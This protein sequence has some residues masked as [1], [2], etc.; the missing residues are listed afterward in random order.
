[1]LKSYNITI[2]VPIYN[3]GKY[4]ARCAESLFAQTLYDI[5]YIFVNDCT[6]DNSI[7]ILNEAIANHPNRKGDIKIISHKVNKG[8]AA[9]RN[10]GLSEATGEYIFHCDSDDWVAI[11][12]CE[13]MYNKAK[14]TDADIVW[15]DYFEDRLNGQFCIMQKFEEDSTKCIK[16]MLSTSMKWNLWNKIFKRSLFIEE[17]V[18]FINGCN[19]GEDL[20]T[21]KMFYYAKK[22]AYLPQA[23]YHYNTIN[24][25]SY[26]S[27]QIMQSKQNE[28]FANI[29]S[30]ETF[31]RETKD[32]A[33]VEPYIHY[34]KIWTKIRIISGNTDKILLRKF[35][36]MYP[37]SNNYMATTPHLSNK[38]K[39]LLYLANKKYINLII[40]YN[41]L[42]KLLRK[43]KIYK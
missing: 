40:V 9:S 19:L 35:C 1:M 41:S 38:A 13:K 32:Y 30:L 42:A 36:N 28:S 17:G 20:A 8:L 31:F 29:E 24:T 34:L 25:S 3:V 37:E 10:A 6:P 15:S 33:V 5:E 18:K 21:I 14:E 16:L 23:F 43:F 4:I 39:Y 26:T 11:D 12:F 22:V 7:E 27:P 2:I